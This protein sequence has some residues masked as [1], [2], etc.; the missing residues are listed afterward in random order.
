VRG[1]L[2]KHFGSGDCPYPPL[3]YISTYTETEATEGA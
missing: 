2:F 1:K 3:I